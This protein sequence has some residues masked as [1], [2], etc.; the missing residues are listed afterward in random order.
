MRTYMLNYVERPVRI[1]YSQYSLGKG[2]KSTDALR[3]TLR[4]LYY[5]VTG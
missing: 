3:L 4:I 1:V 5:K 2:Q